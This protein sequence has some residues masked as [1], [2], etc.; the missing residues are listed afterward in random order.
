MPTL[1]LDRRV[2]KALLRMVY[3]VAMVEEAFGPCG[4]GRGRMLTKTYLSLEQADFC[5]M[6]AALPECAGGKMVNV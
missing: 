5:A 2:W 1:F 4:A 3:V 6:A